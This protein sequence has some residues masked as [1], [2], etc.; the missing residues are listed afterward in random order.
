MT[1][2]PTDQQCALGFEIASR[3]QIPSVAVAR[4]AYGAAAQEIV[5][6]AMKLDPIQINGKAKVCF[7]AV[8]DGMFYEI[9]SVRAGSKVVIYDW[10]L[11]KEVEAGLPVH[12]A[13]LAH[14]I[15]GARTSD[16]MW[17]A[18]ARRNLRIYVLPLNTVVELA[19]TCPLTIPK[20]PLGKVAKR[21]GML[22]SGYAD[23]YRNLGVR[24]L[25]EITAAHQIAKLR[26]YGRSIF[27]EIWRLK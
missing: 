11:K 24:A 18:Y 17:D 22:R 26:I 2:A 19:S 1:L 16:E 15:G 13:I 8:R 10:R 25:E 27:A 23:G 4:N 20:K 3:F 9:K 5:C 6:R 14:R 12:Y 21:F 7:D